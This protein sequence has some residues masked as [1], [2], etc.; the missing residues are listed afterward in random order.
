M[1]VYTLL[2][3]VI[4]SYMHVSSHSVHTFS[5]RYQQEAPPES[6]MSSFAESYNQSHSYQAGASKSNMSSFSVYEDSIER[7]SLAPF[8]DSWVDTSKKDIN[9]QPGSTNYSANMQSAVTGQETVSEC[10]SKQPDNREDVAVHDEVLGAPLEGGGDGVGGGANTSA[11]DQSFY[12]QV[13]ICHP[14]V[15][16]SISTPVNKKIGTHV[17]VHVHV[18]ISQHTMFLCMGKTKGWP[19]VSPS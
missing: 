18:C 17:H 9:R 12:T 19:V 14:K 7:S 13:G 2:S 4:V 6:D 11:V 15:A 5:T 8:H 3:T 16:P 10:Q 1:Y